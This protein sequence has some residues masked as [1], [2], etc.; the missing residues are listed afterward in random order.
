MLIQPRDAVHS[1]DLPSAEPNSLAYGSG[2]QSEL[3]LGCG[4]CF[5]APRGQAVAGP[6]SDPASPGAAQIPSNIPSM[7]LLNLV[8]CSSSREGDLRPSSTPAVVFRSQPQAS[9][10]GWITHHGTAVSTSHGPEVWCRVSQVSVSCGVVDTA[11]AVC[12]DGYRGYTAGT[13]SLD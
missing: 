12:W 2:T 7:N 3:T 6:Q 1:I 10:L 11:T 8:S 4:V 5:R 13:L 9:C